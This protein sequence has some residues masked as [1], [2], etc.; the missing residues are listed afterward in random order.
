[1]KEACQPGAGNE[2]SAARQTRSI[3]LIEGSV[4]SPIQGDVQFGRTLFPV[5]LA[6]LNFLA[7][8]F[9]HFRFD[10]PHECFVRGCGYLGV[11]H[12]RPQR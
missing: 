8:E 10:S 6:K 5:F 2:R 9:R 7:L 11:F 12:H 4:P 1:M 3:P